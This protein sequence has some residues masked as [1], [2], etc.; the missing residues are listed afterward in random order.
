[1]DG[2]T[3]TKLMSAFTLIEVLVVISITAVLAALL[4]PVLSSAKV[5][6][7]KASSMS[8][9]KQTFT[10]SNLYSNDYDDRVPYAVDDCDW[11]DL[12]RSAVDPTLWQTIQQN[13]IPAFSQ[14]L[15]PYGFNRALFRIP[16]G[17]GPE[18]YE[19]SGTSYAYG[20]VLSSAP[21][22]PLETH[23]CPYFFERGANFW[24]GGV[25]DSN[26]EPGE[27]WLTLYF[28]GLVKYALY[29]DVYDRVDECR[30]S[31]TN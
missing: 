4:M 28:D 16:V 8:D 18:Y 9:L 26:L 10:A 17:Q 12:C 27:R 2:K 31:Y 13:H 19:T 29:A 11:R 7:Y 3:N 6:S 25:S 14:A 15:R 21:L 24:N 5:A 20:L 23:A 1:V 22:Q 30:T